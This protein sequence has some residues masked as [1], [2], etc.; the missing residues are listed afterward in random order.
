MD[1]K[2][3]WK[4]IGDKKFCAF[5][6]TSRTET[7]CKNPYNVTGLCNEFSCPLANSQYA[8]VREENSSLY[9]YMKVPERVHKP[10]ITYERVELSKNYE[11]ALLEIE[12]YLEYWDYELIHKC[13]Q[14]F[15]KLT[16]YLRRKENLQ[17]S[18]EMHAIKKKQVRREKAGAIKA[19]NKINF[20]HN[21]EKELY[22]RL[23]DG[24]YG[25]EAKDK[26][27]KKTKEYEFE[28][29]DEEFSHI[30]RKKAKNRLKW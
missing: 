4:N 5:K 27:Q 12:K 14:R 24:I 26:F 23:E 13:K 10:S 19:L 16:L 15:T 28:E 22:K 21:I 17:G 6:M 9:L 7:F 8:T 30:R 29:S 11:T 3:I 18:I 25:I 20:E 1:D 2:N